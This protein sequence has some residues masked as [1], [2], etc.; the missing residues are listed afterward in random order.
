M[1][2]NQLW[3]IRGC[4]ELMA[5]RK[6]PRAAMA[7]LNSILLS[8]D[9][10]WIQGGSKTPG[11]EPKKEQLCG[12]CLCPQ[13]LWCWSSWSSLKLSSDSPNPKCCSPAW[14]PVGER[15]LG[16]TSHPSAPTSREN[17]ACFAHTKKSHRNRS[18]RNYSLPE[19]MVP[20][21]SRRVKYMNMHHN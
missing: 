10:T 14:M 4:T 6:T 16:T 15:G 11:K 8:P 2:K 12:F 17:R 3:L 9:S 5:A 13:Q 19:H 20:R 21:I 1:L 18:Y 7:R